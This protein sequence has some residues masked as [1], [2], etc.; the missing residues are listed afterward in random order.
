MV[1][2]L[3]KSVDERS[4]R[5]SLGQ[6]EQAAEGDQHEDDRQQPVLLTSPDE[7]PELC[8]ELEHLALLELA[9][10]GVGGW[11]RR[12]ALDPVRGRGGIEP[13]MQEV[14]AEHAYHE[15]D[16]RHRGEENQTQDHRVHDGVEQQS[17]AVPETVQRPQDGRPGGADQAERRGQAQ[18]PP[19]DS[20]STEQRQEPDQ[21]ER[22][23]DDQPETPVRPD[24]DVVLADEALVELSQ[25]ARPPSVTSGST[26]HSTPPPPRALPRSRTSSPGASRPP[27][28]SP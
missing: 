13:Q 24:P 6:D 5:A 26:A 22:S 11:A 1:G 21:A 16:R 9:G 20:V 10:H 2:A 23:T 8:H 28:R 12:A 3:E 27:T 17:E 14:L 18:A 19:A 15:A 25:R 7:P 4:D